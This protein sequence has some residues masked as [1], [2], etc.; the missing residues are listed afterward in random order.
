MPMRSMIRAEIL[1]SVSP[2]VNTLAATYWPLAVLKAAPASVVDLAHRAHELIQPFEDYET[3]ARAAGWLPDPGDTLRRV[4]M[5][6]T[7]RNGEDE[8]FYHAANWRE[9]CRR[10]RLAPDLVPVSEHWS[11][12]LWLAERLQEHDARVSLDFAGFNIWARVD[13]GPLQT[14]PCLR[15]IW[16]NSEWSAESRRA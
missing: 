16:R 12:S 3:P 1:D 15:L 11:V 8:S 4:Y 2:L 5:D 7:R 9:A 10:S 14:D 13:S 6:T